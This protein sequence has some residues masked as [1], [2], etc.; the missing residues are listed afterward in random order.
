[1]VHDITLKDRITLGEHTCRAD[2]K[3]PVEPSHPFSFAFYK[4]PKSWQPKSEGPNIPAQNKKNG[5][6]L[7]K[8]RSILKPKNSCSLVVATDS[9]YQRNQWISCINEMATEAGS[10]H[11]RDPLPPK[12][13]LGIIEQKLMLNQKCITQD[14][15]AKNRNADSE[16]VRSN[17]NNMC[18]QCN[19]DYYNVF[20]DNENEKPVAANEEAKKNVAGNHTISSASKKQIST[21]KSD[22]SDSTRISRP[23]L[24]LSA[25]AFPLP[26]SL[27]ISALP[28]RRAAAQS[29]LAPL[30]SPDSVQL[31]QPRGL[32][33]SM[34]AGSNLE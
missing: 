28:S 10:T 8:I 7:N 31:V 11:S 23:R 27:F 1:M 29:M 13:Q 12:D 25:S 19:E 4:S 17:N 5:G 20:N 32:N 33:K 22:K 26:S 2:A 34:R 3:L 6:L 18:L 24:R 21:L 9:E 30:P 14:L 16:A 15:S